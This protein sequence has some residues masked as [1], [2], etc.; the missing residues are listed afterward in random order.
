MLL[1]GWICYEGN[2]GVVCNFCI[3]EN[4]VILLFVNCGEMV[5]N[6]VKLVLEFVLGWFVG[7]FGVY[8]W[9]FEFRFFWVY[10]FFG[11]KYCFCDVIF[12]F[13]FKFDLCIV[14]CIRVFCVVLGNWF[15]NLFLML[16]F[17]GLK[18]C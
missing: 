13:G 5:I 9:V 7:Y 6:C 16:Y 2:V 10:V 1:C 11:L 8:L 14:L 3:K 4:I 12:F 15:W 17:V 18:W